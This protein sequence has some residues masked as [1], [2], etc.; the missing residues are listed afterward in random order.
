MAGV[1]ISANQAASIKIQL[2]ALVQKEKLLLAKRIVVSFNISYD[3]QIN[4]P[5]DQNLSKNLYLAVGKPVKVES[6]VK[7]STPFTEKLND[8]ESQEFKDLANDVIK[9]T[10]PALEETAKK[11][12]AKVSVEVKRFHPSVEKVSKYYI[13]M[14]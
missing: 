12:N 7:L 10:K 4:T 3:L 13:K 9:M 5:K 14:R 1:Q 8:P 6:N 11:N 2:N